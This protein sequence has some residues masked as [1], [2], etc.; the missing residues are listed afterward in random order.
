MPERDCVKL[1]QVGLQWSLKKHFLGTRF[2]DLYHL[3]SDMAKYKRA[4]VAKALARTG[5][6]KGSH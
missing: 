4:R 2:L 6:H 3:S 5:I 1:I